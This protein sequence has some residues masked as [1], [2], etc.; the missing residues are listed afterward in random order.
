MFNKF[1]K[2]Q[3][4]SIADMFQDL[5]VICLTTLGSFQ[6]GYLTI[7]NQYDNVIVLL[8]AVFC[9]IFNMLLRK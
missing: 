5:S 6:A 9:F 7:L 1:N 3:K 4:T 2:E 8:I